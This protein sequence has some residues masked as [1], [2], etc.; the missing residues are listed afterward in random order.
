MYYKGYGN[1]E[2][3]CK[4]CFCYYSNSYELFFSTYYIDRLDKENKTVSKKEVFDKSKYYYDNGYMC[5]TCWTLQEYLMTIE[6]NNYNEYRICE[7]CFVGD[8]NE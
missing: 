1:M 4:D 3:I 2:R 5:S 8:D 7:K 6:D